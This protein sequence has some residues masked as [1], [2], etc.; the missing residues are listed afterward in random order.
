M[1]AAQGLN[2]TWQATWVW[3]EC[4]HPL[5]SQPC[6]Y[7]K[8]C[9]FTAADPGEG[10]RP[11]GLPLIFRQEKILFATSPPLY[12]VWMTAPTPLIRRSGSATAIDVIFQQKFP[13]VI[14]NWLN[15]FPQ[16]IINWLIA[17]YAFSKTTRKGKSLC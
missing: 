10:P 14:I 2:W 15:W 4:S 9:T 11:S 1:A 12:R 7:A 16:V 5:C 3:G 6:L 17:M 8:C 13:Q